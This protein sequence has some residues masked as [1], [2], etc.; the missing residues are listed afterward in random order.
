M[1]N[2]L[3]EKMT[4]R[5]MA[6]LLFN[7]ATLLRGQGNVNPYRTAA[8]ERGAR[9]LMGLSNEASAILQA[10]DRVPFRRR[11]RIGKKLQAKIR[12]MA[13][14]GYLEQ[15][16]DMVLELPEPF[17]QLMLVPGIGPKSAEHIYRTLSITTAA[18]LVRAARD[19][20]LRQVWGFGPRR[21][22]ALAALDL[23]EEPVP[24]KEKRTALPQINLFDLSQ[25]A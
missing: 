1:N 22:A 17:A 25:T 23:W 11:Q 16:V 2:V 20:H 5:E 10:E 15:Y 19:G 6:S 9:A 7:I 18:D 24:E 3:S 14:T 8:Y 4:N 21:I 13:Q 12:E